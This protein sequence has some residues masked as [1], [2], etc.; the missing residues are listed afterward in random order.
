[1]VSGVGSESFLLHDNCIL[2]LIITTGHAGHGEPKK[3]KKSKTK[4][5][6]LKG[7]ED[8][9]GLDAQVNHKVQFR[10]K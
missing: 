5:P 10:F 6:K 7:N 1:M 3:E 4:V 8:K 2:Y 9:Y